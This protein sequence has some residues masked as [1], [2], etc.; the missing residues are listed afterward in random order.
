MTL[1]ALKTTLVILTN[2]RAL[3]LIRASGLARGFIRRLATR[4]SC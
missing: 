3:Y 1:R 4:W 2:Q